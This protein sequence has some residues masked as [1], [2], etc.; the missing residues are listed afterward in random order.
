M[1]QPVKHLPS[2]QGPGIKPCTGLPAQRKSASPSPFACHFPCLCC[3][4]SLS[5]K[6]N[7][8]LKKKEH[9]GELPKITAIK[10]HG[11]AFRLGSV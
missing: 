9:V 1:A 6:I 7:K 4:I 11:P 8:I 10:W 2:A 3:S 5:N